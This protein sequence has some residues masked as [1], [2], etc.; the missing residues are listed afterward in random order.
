MA[1]IQGLSPAGVVLVHGMW[2]A[3]A[4]WDW[5]RQEL[6]QQADI[7]VTVPDLPSHRFPDAGLL[8]DV[9]EVRTAIAASPAPAVVVGWSYGCDVVGVAAHGMP[10]VARLVYVSSVPLKVHLDRHDATFV[11]GMK[12][13]LR[14]N[15]GPF[16]LDTNW[17]PNKDE[18]GLRLPRDVRAY[19]EA[20]PRRFVTTEARASSSL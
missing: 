11:D 3:P 13:M 18:A 6:E 19:L 10:N 5:A 16:A 2:G 20:T 9:D 15:H 14:D 7:H 8:E 17:W 4:D 1:G 12:H